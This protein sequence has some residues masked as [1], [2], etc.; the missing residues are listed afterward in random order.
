METGLEP[1]MVQGSRPRLEQVLSN[2]IGNAIKY[3]PD[4]GEISVT[5]AVDGTFAIV[6]VEDNG[7]GI[8]L[9]EQPFI[10]DSSIRVLRRR[11]RALV[12][13]G[14]G[15][16]IVKSIMKSMMDGSGSRVSPTRGAVSVFSCR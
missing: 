10:F 4:G 15:L 6:S 12:E 2:L 16:S 5:S 3:T 8:P 11:P 1:L 14:L 7:I 9:S 13:Q